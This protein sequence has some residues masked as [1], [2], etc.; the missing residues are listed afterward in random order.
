[1]KKIIKTIGIVMVVAIIMLQTNVKA[2]SVDSKTKIDVTKYGEIPIYYTGEE[3]EDYEI[4]KYGGEPVYSFGRTTGNNILV[5]STYR[6]TDSKIETI[7]LNGY[8]IK[9]YEEL[10][11]NSEEEAYIATQEAIFAY[12]ENKEIDMYVAENE[13]GERILNCMKTLLNSTK[14]SIVKLVELNEEW[15][16]LESNKNYIYKNYRVTSDYEIESIEIDFYDGLIYSQDNN[17]INEANIGDVIKIAVPNNANKTY[18]VSI[19]FKFEGYKLY[20]MFNT[21]AT[22]KRYMSMQYENSNEYVYASVSVNNLT[23]VT[24]MNYDGE[25]NEAID[26]NTFSILDEDEKVVKSGLITDENGQIQIELP[27]GEYYLKQT[28]A[29]DGY[30]VIGRKIKFSV[31]SNNEVN[32]NIYSGTT[33]EKTINKSSTQ[34]NVTEETQNIV[35]NEVEDITNIKTNNIIKE[36]VKQTNITN[37]EDNNYF[38]NTI[39]QKNIN[40]VTRDNK[41]DNTIWK[42]NIEYYTLDGANETSNISRDEYITYIDFIKTANIE[43]PSLPSAVK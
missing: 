9:T 37:L 2:F 10:G 24:I 35:E 22:E 8:P 20:A 13:Q 27:K 41:Y 23:S 4:L 26:G 28:N 43:A 5:T 16:V 36:I 40:Q 42:E 3:K 31:K 12:I 32:L 29:K 1:M 19:S 18:H 21:S 7:L 15:T 33:S 11:L 38:T 6:Y 14:E 34:I 17:S 25:T 39:Y 30:S